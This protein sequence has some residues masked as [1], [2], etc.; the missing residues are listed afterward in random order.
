MS[1][2]KLNAASFCAIALFAFQANV[3]ATPSYVDVSDVTNSTNPSLWQSESFDI[4]SLAIGA[5]DAKLSFDLRNDACHGAG[6]AARCA[7]AVR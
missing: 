5:A 3:T 1:T 4:T 7:V 2:S 6:S